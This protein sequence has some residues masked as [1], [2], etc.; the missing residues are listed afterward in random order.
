MRRADRLVFVPPAALF[1]A[2]DMSRF[3]LALAHDEP[4]GS[5]VP[6]L[7]AVGWASLAYYLWRQRT[8][9]VDLGKGRTAKVVDVDDLTHGVKMTVQSLLPGRDNADHAYLNQLRMRELLIAHVVTEWSLEMPVP[10]GDPAKLVAVPGSAYE[11]LLEATEP[12]WESL[13]FLRVGSNSSSSET[14]SEDTTAPDN[15]PASEQ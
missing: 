5:I 1:A 13:D 10:G 2:S 12:H 11:K 6:L 15:S 14:P 3:A 7:A 4:L 8:M 9:H